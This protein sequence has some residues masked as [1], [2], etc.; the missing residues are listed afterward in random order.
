MI[1]AVLQLLLERMVARHLHL[2]L[3]V[4][5]L[6]PARRYLVAR[7]PLAATQ[8]TPDGSPL[9]QIAAAVTD[10]VTALLPLL[11]TDR[12][13]EAAGGLKQGGGYP[14]LPAAH[15]H[16]TAWPTYRPDSPPPPTSVAILEAH[17]TLQGSGRLAF[18]G[19]ASVDLLV[20]DAARAAPPRLLTSSRVPAMAIPMP[21]VP[22]P[23]RNGSGADAWSS[24]PWRAARM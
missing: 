22:P 13:L 18:M 24:G 15:A 4:T 9:P 20:T 3:V 14:Q 12:P 23:T 1:N 2:S 19:F 7:M 5:Q 16:A 21:P 6:D 17:G 8:L 11:D 10:V